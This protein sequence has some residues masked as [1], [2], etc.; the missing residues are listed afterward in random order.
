MKLIYYEFP[1]K[2]EWTYS[3][4]LTIII[5]N[6]H[7]LQQ[8]IHS[9]LDDR[10]SNK[11]LEIFDDEDKSMNS[12]IE[13]V[14]EPFRLYTNNSYTQ[15][16]LK[17]YLQK[18]IMEEIVRYSH[19]AQPIWNLLNGLLIDLPLEITIDNEINPRSLTS[20][21][22]IAIEQTSETLLESI[23]DYMKVMSSLN[24]KQVF[25]FFNLKEILTELELKMLIEH[26]V[27]EEIYLVL[28][29]TK[30][31]PLLDIERVY[32]VDQD[33]CFIYD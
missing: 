29:E 17:N 25:I 31:H 22:G 15:N 18:N 3:E 11:K 24:I 21:F 9:I 27:I 16:F 6:K 10:S 30:H 2:I 7:F 26:A 20:L 1:E 33:I 32:V 12:K 14:L 5:E 19:Q 4:V 13:L 23:I 8:F 28:L